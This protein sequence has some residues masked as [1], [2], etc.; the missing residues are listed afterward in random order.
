MASWSDDELRTCSA[1]QRQQLIW[2]LEGIAEQADLFAPAA[3]LLLR[4][5]ETDREPLR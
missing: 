2:A 1:M 4:L 3:G 5:A